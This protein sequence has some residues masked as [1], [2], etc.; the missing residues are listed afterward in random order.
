MSDKIPAGYTVPFPQDIM[1]PPTVKTRIGDFDFFDGVP[2]D[3]TVRKL[4]DYLD[5]NRAVDVYLN[6]LQALFIEGIRLSHLELGATACNHALISEQLVDAH[7]MWP[8]T[9]LDTVYCSAMLDLERDGATVVEIPPKC[10][11]STVDDAWMRF[12]IDMGP[13]GPDRG[14]GGT[15]VILP[16]DYEGELDP[17]PGGMEA[18]M[19]IAGQVQKVFVAKSSTYTNWLVLRGFLVDGKPDAAVQMFKSGLKLYPLKDAGDPPE[20]KFINVAGVYSNVMPPASARYFEMLNTIIQKESLGAIDPERRG[21][22]AAI[23]IEKGNPFRPDERM[24][25]IYA[26]A[27]QIGDA[28]GRTI[29]FSPRE[30]EAYL[31]QDRQWYMSFVGGRSDWLKDDGRGGIYLDARITFHYGA[32][33]ITPAMALKMVGVGSQYAFCSRDKDGQY[34]DGGKRYKL[35]LPPN[36]P[37]KDFWSVVAYDTQTRCIMQVPGQLVPGKNNKK[38]DLIYNADGSIDLYFGPEAP[39]KFEDNW[40]KTAPGRA[41]FVLLRL[42]GPLEPW[43]DKTWKPDDFELV[44][45]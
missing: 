21:D 40:I 11:P 19:E 26:E 37:A 25:R 9:N 13:P 23:G 31:Y 10:G 17:P 38:D 18:E 41:W 32:I 22:I 24:E 16:P 42:Y 27:A 36:I 14:Q 2:T 44:S 29:M 33:V 15:Y 35:H 5:F 28:I 45:D 20:M 6:N 39:A 30:K 7:L 12:I 1:V 4:Y 43:F 34:L 8:T 3:E